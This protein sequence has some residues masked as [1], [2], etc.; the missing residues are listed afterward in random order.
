MTIVVY[1]SI[2]TSNRNDSQRPAIIDKVVY[3]SI[4]TSNRNVYA[5]YRQRRSLYIVLFLHQTATLKSRY[6]G[7]FL[8]Y[9]VLFL[10]QTATCASLTLNSVRLYIVLF[11]H[12]TA[13][14]RLGTLRIVVLYIVLFLHQTATR[15]FARHCQNCCISFYSYIKPQQFS[16]VQCDPQVVYR[17]IP[18][19][20]RNISTAHVLFLRVV[21]RSIPTSNRNMVDGFFIAHFVVYRSIPTSNRN[22][23]L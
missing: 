10:H 3:R 12:Q 14:L 21:Y 4:P 9:I 20:N 13:T 1:R 22:L 2:P 17:S 23:I 8:L 6:I 16:R 11:L 18:T 7:T 5:W 19:S 15:T